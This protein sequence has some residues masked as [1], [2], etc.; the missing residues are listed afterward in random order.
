MARGR[1][2]V[3]MELRLMVPNKLTAERARVLVNKLLDIGV[4]DA[5]DTLNDGQK[6]EDA[7]DAL[8]LVLTEPTVKEDRKLVEG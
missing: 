5:V 1:R 3:V 4:A 8:S 6:D 2:M 7:K